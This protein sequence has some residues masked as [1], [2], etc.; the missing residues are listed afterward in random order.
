MPLPRC[1]FYLLLGRSSK[2]TQTENKEI[3]ETRSSALQL[4]TRGL[5]LMWFFA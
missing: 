1:N 4:L 2:H 5:L 3:F